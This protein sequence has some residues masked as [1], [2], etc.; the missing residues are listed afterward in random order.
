[1]TEIK[2]DFAKHDYKVAINRDKKKN[3]KK[4]SKN[5]VSN[6]GAKLGI[7]NENIGNYNNAKYAKLPDNIRYKKCF[8]NQFINVNYAYKKNK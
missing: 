8:S 7:I 4:N 1:M 6:P 3:P 2:K 5:F